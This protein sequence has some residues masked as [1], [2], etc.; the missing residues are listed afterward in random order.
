M[1]LDGKGFGILRLLILS[2]APADMTPVDPV[3]L[4]T[5]SFRMSG[6]TAYNDS[7]DLPDGISGFR[8]RSIISASGYNNEVELPSG[9]AL[10]RPSTNSNT[11]GYN[12]AVQLPS[13]QGLFRPSSNSQTIGYNDSVS[14]P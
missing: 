10:F 4:D 7:V 3:M 5:G 2:S 1:D 13:G 6:T 8:P 14:L 11:T 9:D 12:E